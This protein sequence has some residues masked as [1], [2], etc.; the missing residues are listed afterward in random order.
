MVEQGGPRRPLDDID[1]F[2]LILRVFGEDVVVE[3]WT[4]LTVSST[5]EESG[6]GGLS[7][8]R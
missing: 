4:V 6:K 8:S 1:A 2:N 3:C 7:W 5:H